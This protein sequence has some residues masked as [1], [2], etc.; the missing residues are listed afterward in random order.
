MPSEGGNEE[1]VVVKVVVVVVVVKVVV[2]EEEEEQALPQVTKVTKCA[3]DADVLL[4][5]QYFDCDWHMM[6]LHLQH[7]AAVSTCCA[8]GSF[9]ALQRM[10]P[11]D[12]STNSG[13]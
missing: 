3:A 2:E 7:A 1:V 9:N 13:A 12:G 8:S 4:V 6:R 5:R 11:F 10:Q